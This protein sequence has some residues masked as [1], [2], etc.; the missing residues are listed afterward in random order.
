M[1]S[2]EFCKISKNTFFYRTP[3][4]AASEN[5]IKAIQVSA[6]F[7]PNCNYFTY[8]QPD[9]VQLTFSVVKKN[10]NLAPGKI[11]YIF[12]DLNI[13]I[14]DFNEFL[15]IWKIYWSTIRIKLLPTWTWILSIKKHKLLHQSNTT[16]PNNSK[17]LN[18]S[19]NQIQLFQIIQKF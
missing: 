6:N 3:P 18:C 16:V 13:T 4:A 2:C 1:F 5:R 8:I 17:V 7:F 11:I 10:V 12:F 15:L 14:Q 9:L 19:T